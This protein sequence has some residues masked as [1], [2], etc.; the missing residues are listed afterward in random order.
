MD[1]KKNIFLVNTFF[2]IN[3]L[4][5]IFTFYKLAAL[6]SSESDRAVIL[7]F[8]PTRLFMFLVCIVG[9][10]L[11]LF[12]FFSSRKKESFI[13]KFIFQKAASFF[14]I[15]KFSLA[16]ILA[17]FLLFFFG[18]LVLNVLLNPAFIPKSKIYLY[19]Y[20][21]IKPQFLWFV[22]I[23]GELSALIWIFYWRDYSKVNNI[24]SANKRIN[25]LSFLSALLSWILMGILW[26]FYANHLQDFSKY[27]FI[28]PVLAIILLL[29]NTPLLISITN[30][31]SK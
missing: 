31:Y 6:P 8:S 12:L 1:N 23:C 16:I 2:L 19:L 20:E 17:I 3:I 13:N 28:I 10:L 15:N 11:F 9:I 5:G 7:G 29:L 22:L 26:G 27:V 25:L 30:K 4:H 21:R 18:G 14:K 24:N